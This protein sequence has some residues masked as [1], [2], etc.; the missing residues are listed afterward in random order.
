[1]P[2]TED[3]VSIVVKKI[4][5]T[6]PTHQYYF[7]PCPNGEHSCH[8]SRHRQWTSAKPSRRCKT[9]D[10]PWLGG[11]RG[12]VAGDGQRVTLKIESGKCRLISCRCDIGDAST[13][14]WKTWKPDVYL[15][16]TDWR[17]AAR[18]LCPDKHGSL[19]GR[20]LSAVAGVQA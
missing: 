19:E 3:C 20:E 4:E 7:C 6:D 2:A 13:Y 12:T 8:P 15:G 17:Q 18:E 16:W 11:R 1:M 5:E 14:A 10:H 9:R